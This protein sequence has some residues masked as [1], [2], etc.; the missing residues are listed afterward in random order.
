MREIRRPLVTKIGWAASDPWLVQ[1]PAGDSIASRRFGTLRKAYSF[2]LYQALCQMVTE[3][4]LQYHQEP[5]H[6]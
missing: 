4:L 2:A 3:C 1:W 6:A 5:D